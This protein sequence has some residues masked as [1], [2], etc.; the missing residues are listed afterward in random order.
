M[1]RH[2]HIL[3]LTSIFLIGLFLRLYHLGSESLWTDEGIAI[4]TAESGI[5]EI[6][7]ERASFFHGP[8][9]YILLRYWIGIFGNTEYSIRFLSAIF[10]VLAI[11]II[12]KVGEIIFNKEIG[13]LSALLLSISSFHISYSQEARMYSLVSM[14]TLSSFYFFIRLLSFRAKYTII[15]YILSSVLLFYTHCIGLFVIMAQVIF[16]VLY[17]IK[18]R[19]LETKKLKFWFIQ[20]SLLTLLLLPLLSFF[21]TSKRFSYLINHIYSG[22]AY[23]FIFP[24][25][26][27]SDIAETA[28]QWSSR[29]YFLMMISLIAV[30]NFFLNSRNRGAD[31]LE[32]NLK[33]EN[34]LILLTWLIIP[35]L[36]VFLILSPDRF[37]P[38]YAIG[39]STAFYIA[40][41][42]GLLTVKKRY[43]K[44]IG[45]CLI[46]SFSTVSLFQYFTTNRNADY[47]SA[48]SYFDGNANVNDAVFFLD[49][50]QMYLFDH[51]SNFSSKANWFILRDNVDLKNYER[52]W[53]IQGKPGMFTDKKI[54]KIFDVVYYNVYSGEYNA[55][56]QT[57]ILYLYKKRE[58]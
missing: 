46:F 11:L 53:F 30:L 34:A 5:N 56:D 42:V 20:L 57:L 6:I 35:F 48:A 43:I 26:R 13:L 33:K 32:G 24:V 55:L 50:R 8:L 45:V 3:V 31:V 40:T 41:A 9:Y 44:V 51:Y 10:G 58:G 18:Y 39:S 1:R 54:D 12:Y 19:R 28:F 4:H 16:L 17:S 15:G 27:F 2:L 47:R 21:A 22:Q 49:K 29:S 36:L 7:K 52:L 14:L 38:K 25:R 23:F 37:R